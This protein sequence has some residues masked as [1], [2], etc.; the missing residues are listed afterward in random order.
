[1]AR[2]LTFVSVVIVAVTA[3]LVQ[4]PP[5]H[6]T[7]IDNIRG[8]V[9]DLRETSGCPPL[10]YSFALEKGA[11]IFVRGGNPR[12]NNEYLGN[13]IA[14]KRSDDP[15]ADA[16][17]GLLTD[18]GYNITNCNWTD[19]GVGFER[20]E[21][22]EESTVSF[23]LGMAENPRSLPRVARDALLYPRP[24]DGQTP[25]GKVPAGT[26]VHVME[27]MPFWAHIQF[28]VMTHQVDGWVR[29]Q[30]LTEG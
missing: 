2:A 6:A 8:A 13:I 4:S 21:A 29:P 30:F 25:Y 22:L 1:M 19:V 26:T 10:R 24:A 5:G 16:T 23:V 28:F 17:E 12:D 9:N 20:N 15:T 3:A 14:Y 7:P 11:N 18:Y 27:R